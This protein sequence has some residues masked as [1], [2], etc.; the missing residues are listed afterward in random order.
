[1]ATYKFYCIALFVLVSG[2][3][4]SSARRALLTLPETVGHVPVVAGY[5]GGGG[6][7][8]GGGSGAVGGVTGYASGGG[9]GEGGGAGYGGAAGGSGGGGGGGGGGCLAELEVQD[10][11][12][13]VAKE[14]VPDM[15]EVVLPEEVAVE[16]AAEEVEDL[17]LE[18]VV[19]EAVKEV[20]PAVAM[21]LEE[22]AL[23]DMEVVE[24]VEEEGE[25]VTLG[26]HLV[27]D[28]AVEEELVGVLL[29]VDTPEAAAAALVGAVEGPMVAVE[30]L[31]AVVLAVGKVAAMAV[32]TFLENAFTSVIAC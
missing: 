25:Q 30:Q 2:L 23:V 13:G 9:G 1:M 15:V 28:M 27:V 17:A 16:V 29:L 19:M 10:M 11:E 4:I 7:G 5:G 14:V 20:V 6:A 21:V 26:E 31:M 8:G 32:A 12:V 18:A 3:G 24:G 22:P